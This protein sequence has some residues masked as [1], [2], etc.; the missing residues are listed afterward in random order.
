MNYNLSEAHIKIIK[1]ILTIW[2]IVISTVTLANIF[3]FVSKGIYTHPIMFFACILTITSYINVYR[4][5]SMVY[6]SNQITR[7]QLKIWSILFA[8]GIFFSCLFFAIYV[9]NIFGIIFFALTYLGTF[10]CNHYLVKAGVN[11]K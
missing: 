2:T 4:F 3:V 11:E 5:F 1:V 10:F 6:S 7:L 8:R 9:Q